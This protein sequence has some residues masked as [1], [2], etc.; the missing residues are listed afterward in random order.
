VLS[1]TN[2]ERIRRLVAAGKMTPAG[3]AALRGKLGDPAGKAPPFKVPP[4]IL[5]ALR[6]D[7]S[8][9]KDFRA[10]PESYKRVRVGWIG[11]ARKRP[12]VFAQ[13][14]RYFVRMTAANKRFGMVQ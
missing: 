3:L 6:A 7:R 1:A 11:A 10:F 13:R 5:A 2:V 9:W 8:A 14:L 12:D 4:D